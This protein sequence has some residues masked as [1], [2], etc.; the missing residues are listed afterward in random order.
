M[1]AA[2]VKHGGNV[3]CGIEIDDGYIFTRAT[4]EYKDGTKVGIGCRTNEDG[5][6]QCTVSN[7]EGNV[8]IRA[9]FEPVPFKPTPNLTVSIAGDEFFFK[10]M[11]QS[12]SAAIKNTGKADANNVAWKAETKAGKL[13]D[14][15][16]IDS[17]PAGESQPIEIKADEADLKGAEVCVTVDPDH[18]IEES[19]DEDNT[20]CAK[21]KLAAT[22]A[23][24][25]APVPTMSDIGLLLSSLALAG[26]AAP[27]LRR[28]ERKESEQRQQD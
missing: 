6:Y 4:A 12:S 9:T 8:T 18:E 5:E 10:A 17:L 16:A 11:K 19:N 24:T 13:L 7:I 28:C 14:S 21:V 25:A 20:A 15:G 27:A 2:K 22:A 1:P 23:A 26:A 3:T